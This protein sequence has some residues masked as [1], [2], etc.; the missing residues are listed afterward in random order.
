MRIGFFCSNYTSTKVKS[1][2]DMPPIIK[3]IIGICHEKLREPYEIPQSD[4]QKI[5]T[6]EIKALGL[7]L[8][9]MQ[10]KLEIPDSSRFNALVHSMVAENNEEQLTLESTAEELDR[11]LTPPNLK[12]MASLTKATFGIHE[13]EEKYPFVD[14]ESISLQELI[15]KYGTKK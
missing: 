15:T 4:L 3:T 13:V 5:R 14:L 7:F 8:Q 9:T 6:G 1:S 10:S 2:M 11:I 12:K